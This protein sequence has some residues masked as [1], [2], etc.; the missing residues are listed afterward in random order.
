MWRVRGARPG[1][2]ARQT[3]GASSRTPQ[4]AP[5]RARRIAYV[6]PSMCAGHGMLCPY[7]E[8]TGISFCRKGI[9]AAA[10]SS[11]LSPERPKSA[12]VAWLGST[13][14]LKGMP[15]V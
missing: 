3:A 8:L 5:L 15:T 6:T 12:A 10:Q 2:P 7:G 11:M 14:R 1:K 13:V 4:E 9:L